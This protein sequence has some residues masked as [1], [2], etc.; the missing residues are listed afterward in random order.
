MIIDKLTKVTHFLP[1]RISYALEKLALPLELSYV[2]NV[3]HVSML[4][5]YIW[6][7]SHVLE[8]IPLDIREDLSYEE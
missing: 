5:R 3:F 1:I 4:R 8:Y 2:H 6:D 7:L